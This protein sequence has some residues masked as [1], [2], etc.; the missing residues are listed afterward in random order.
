M[1]RAAH[2]PRAVCAIICMQ[3]LE[4]RAA[5]K[6]CWFWRTYGLS[7]QRGGFV[8]AVHVSGA[9]ARMYPLVSYMHA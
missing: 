2:V 8:R 9:V 7:M 3:V 1:Q 6:V 5:N 4:V